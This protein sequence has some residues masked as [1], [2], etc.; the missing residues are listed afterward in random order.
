MMELLG[1]DI[2]GAIWITTAPYK[3]E[4]RPH[5]AKPEYIISTGVE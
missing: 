4:M 5:P 1:K 2:F 3:I